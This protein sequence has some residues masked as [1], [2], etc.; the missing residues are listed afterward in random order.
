[1]ETEQKFKVAEVKLTY[2]TRLKPKER[3]HI[4]CSQDAYNILIKYAYDK[5]T[6][7][8]RESFKVMLLN[9][10][11]K[12]LGIVNLSDGGITGTVV[13]LRMVFQAAIKANACAV[14]I[15]H[16]HPSGMLYPSEYDKTVTDKIKD[17]GKILDISLHDHIIVTNEDYYSFMDKGLL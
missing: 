6:I 11:N 3:Y 7:E 12:V 17:A 14:I 8:H 5:D 1:M 4:K 15:S 9:R 10:A 16:N 2:S 13:D